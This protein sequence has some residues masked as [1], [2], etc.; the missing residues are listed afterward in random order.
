MT[1]NT[2]KRPLVCALVYDGLCLFEFGIAAE[3]FGLPRPEF[4]AWYDFKTVAV[5]DGPCRAFG[6]LSLMS[7]HGLEA[8][9]EASLI[10]VPGWRGA[11]EPVPRPLVE[12]LQRAHGRGVRLASIC[13]GVFVLAAAGLLEG[14]QAT[15][16]WRYATKLQDRYPSL[17]VDADVL[18]IDEGGVLTSAGSASGLDLCLHIVRQD[19][20]VKVANEVAKRLV[21]PA[22]RE[23][24]Q[25]Q[26]IPRPMPRE[27]GGQIAKLLDRV[28][29][30]LN[31]DWGVDRMADEAGLSSRTLLRRFVEATG[32]SPKA[33]IL[34]E[35]LARARELLESSDIGLDDLTLACGIGAPE[36]LRHH[37]RKRFGTSP[38]QY[39]ARF[40]PRV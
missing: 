40:R 2:P 5:D 20:G 14:R 7:D 17:R 10:I 29:L 27:R 9:E 19:F 35:R 18:Y 33:W 15:T 1:E 39:R 13:S 21:L 30:R 4:E 23:G 25:A 6:G 24:G 38:M 37:F 26:Y 36:T 28:R 31:E 32:E 3:V 8:L 16:H 12:A 34:S 11:D 22:H